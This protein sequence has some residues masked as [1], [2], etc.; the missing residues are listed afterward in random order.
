MEENDTIKSIKEG[1]IAISMAYIYLILVIGISP[2]LLLLLP[3][4]FI[5]LGIRN[6]IYTSIAGMTVLT[7]ILGATESTSLAMSSFIVFMPFIITVQYFIEEKQSLIKTIFIGA[8]VIVISLVLI[9]SIESK[10]SG[11]NLAEEM[12]KGFNTVMEMQLDMFK[13]LDL[14]N[15]EMNNTKEMLKSSYKYIMVI[16]PSIFIVMSL[17]ASY[18]NYKLSTFILNNMGYREINVP[19]FSLL[20]LPDNILIGTATVLMATVIIERLELDYHNALTANVALL[21]GVIFFIQGLS[22]FSYLLKRFKIGKIFRIILIAV[23]LVYL[24]IRMIFILVG[25]LDSIIDFR[26]IRNKT[27]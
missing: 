27:L 7:I 21:I 20:R 11:I 12:E 25:F 15:S 24:P 14:T 8:M 18:L 17:I 3:V 26:K 5:V 16:L 6:N 13:E 10:I 19:D 4:P 9:L 1:I 22:L 23:N 2:V